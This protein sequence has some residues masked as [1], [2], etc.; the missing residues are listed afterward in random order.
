MIKRP[1]VDVSAFLEADDDQGYGQEL[2]IGM[3]PIGIYNS[4]TAIPEHEEC[5]SDHESDT[6]VDVVKTLKQTSTMNFKEKC[7]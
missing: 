2:D 3:G 6:T 5:D 7:P 1:T 4:S